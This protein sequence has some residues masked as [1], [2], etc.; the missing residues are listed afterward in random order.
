MEYSIF[1]I[2]N[3]I[4]TIGKIFNIINVEGIIKGKNLILTQF[5]MDRLE[6]NIFCKMLFN[7]YDIS[8]EL[9]FY[10]GEEYRPCNN[11]S[12]DDQKFVVSQ[13]RIEW[14]PSVRNYTSYDISPFTPLRGDNNFC[15]NNFCDKNGFYLTFVPEYEEVFFNRGKKESY[16]RYE[17]LDL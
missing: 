1:D 8:S 9:E 15:D 2:R 4:Y 7:I 16:N 6:D 14:A 3:E 10:T 12:I 11:I 5:S 13:L 17:I